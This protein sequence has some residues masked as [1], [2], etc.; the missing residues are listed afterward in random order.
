MAGSRLESRR[1]RRGGVLVG[2]SVPVVDGQSDRA[3]ADRRVRVGRVDSGAG[4]PITEVPAVGQLV[5]VRVEAPAGVELAGETGAARGELSRGRL[6]RGGG[7][8]A[9]VDAR[10]R[11][12]PSAT[13]SDS[14][15]R[16][17]PRLCRV[18]RRRWNRRALR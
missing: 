2:V 11:T 15:W 5:S 12:S 1:G 17:G 13:R 18:G 14:W 3:R 10:P 8:S 7:V 6:I 4:L 9:G 16:F